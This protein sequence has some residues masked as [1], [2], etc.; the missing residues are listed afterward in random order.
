MERQ[1]PAVEMSPLPRSRRRRRRR[2]SSRRV[3]NYMLC[4]LRSFSNK[5]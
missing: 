2:R 4:M 5:I 1:I 3:E